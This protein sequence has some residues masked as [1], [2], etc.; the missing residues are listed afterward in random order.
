MKDI[1]SLFKTFYKDF[2]ETYYE[3]N[4][5]ITFQKKDYWK[6]NT[7]I[8]NGPKYVLPQLMLPLVPFIAGK[9][10]A[11]TLF[12]RRYIKIVQTTILTE[13]VTV[14]HFV[15]YIADVEGNIYWGV[16]KPENVNFKVVEVRITKGNRKAVI[17]FKV[18]PSTKLV[19][20][21]YV[22]IDGEP[23]S[24]SDLVDQF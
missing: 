20:I 16:F 24:F 6:G 21:G 13:D 9:S 7:F 18:N 4:D 15:T 2:S 22:G 12:D 3:V 1:K 19:K 8:Y 5:A 11:K 23:A 10:I 14:E 17:Q